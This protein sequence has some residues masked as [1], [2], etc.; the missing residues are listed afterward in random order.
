MH[1]LAPLLIKN[2]RFFLLLLLRFLLNSMFSEFFLFYSF[3]FNQLIDSFH[4]FYC[5][6]Q[7]RLVVRH[8]IKSS[9]LWIR[10]NNCIKRNNEMWITANEVSWMEIS[11]RCVKEILD[12][13]QNKLNNHEKFP[14]SIFGFTQIPHT[15]RK[16]IEIPEFLFI[17]L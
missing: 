17:A 6:W 7:W 5:H 15:E 2:C 14:C 4:I 3:N 1:L 10:T 8:W 12:Y 16:K 9:W 13:Q 11:L